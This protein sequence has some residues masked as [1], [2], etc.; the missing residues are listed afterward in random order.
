MSTNGKKTL[1][2]GI[3]LW[4]STFTWGQIK[5]VYNVPSPEV[6]SL[7][8]Y[9]S[10]PVGHF[11]GIP[12][13]SIPLYEVKMGSFSLPITASYHLASVKPTTT[14][15]VLGFGWS[16]NAGGYITRTVRFCYDE[17]TEKKDGIPLGYY[18]N[19]TKMKDITGQKFDKMMD[20]HQRTS[21][22]IDLSAD[23]FHFNFCGYTG[24]FYYA[25]DGTWKVIS[26]Q[27]IKVEFDAAKDG[28]I[29]LENIKNDKQPRI[30]IPLAW[31]AAS[32]NNR[33]FH[34]FTLVTPDGYR[35]EFGGIH[36]MEFSISY[37]SRIYEDLIPTTWWLSKITS[38]SNRTISFKYQTDS[39]TCDLKY[40]PQLRLLCNIEASK[41]LKIY[42]GLLGYTGF[43]LF[44]A[45][46]QS[47]STENETVTF[48]YYK[49]YGHIFKQKN[50]KALFWP[51]NEGEQIRYSGYG[52]YDKLRDPYKQFHLFLSLNP[53]NL[54][55]EDIARALASNILSGM[56]I[57][58]DN[59]TVEQA[60]NFKY[61]E[62]GMKKLS[63]ITISEIDSKGNS[64][65][66][67]KGYP[68]YKFYYNEK[69]IQ[70]PHIL[71]GTDSWGYY[72]GRRKRLADRPDFNQD[73]PVPTNA[74][75]ETL[76]EIIYPTGGKTVFKYESNAYSK[77]VESIGS[78]LKSDG[79]YH[80]SGGLR[81]K[82]INNINADDSLMTTTRYYYTEDK[83][84]PN[85]SSGVSKNE[86]IQYLVFRFL[87]GSTYEFGSKGGIFPETVDDNS[88]SVGY[89]YVIEEKFDAEGHSNGHIRYRYSNF[90]TD[91]ESSGHLD[92]LASH[93][94]HIDKDN[95]T[96]PFTS[97][98]RER[99]KLLSKEY[100]DNTGKLIKREDIKYRR[101]EDKPFV[102]AHQRYIFLDAY[103][104]DIYIGWLT[105]THTYSYL[106]VRTEETTYF[107]PGD[108]P[109]TT[110]KEIEYTENKMIRTEKEITSKGSTLSTEYK[111]VSDD[112]QYSWLTNRHI[113]SSLI[114]K[115]TS[116]EGQE[117]K[118]EY[119]YTQKNGIPYLSD[120]NLTTNEPAQT[121]KLY[122]VLETDCYANPISLF[123]NG[124]T[125]TL[126]WG[127]KG[128]KLIAKIQN[129]AYDLIK[130]KLGIDISSYSRKDLKDINYN[131]ITMLRT[132]L[133]QA[134]FNIY[135]Y[136]NALRLVSE[137]LP[138]GITTYYKYDILGRLRESYFYD[139]LN[140]KST[141][142][143]YDYHY[144]N[145]PGQ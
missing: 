128:Q 34:K 98:S 110:T 101:T 96:F 52:F 84:R 107:Q 46:I 3:F 66:K 70:E 114:S 62:N 137:T 113:L 133:P 67:G 57:R 76:S 108:I 112:N 92:E 17:R 111:Y 10:I 122:N 83:K 11:T 5:P 43:L 12:D 119:A 86:I 93:S 13:I 95:P 49:D 140:G 79:G 85:T 8:Q 102:V 88:P 71:A 42:K 15:N 145:N 33:F 74:I 28:F 32:S 81:I 99:G 105:N 29:S 53:D 47:I 130:F 39:R 26:D 143:E 65:N 117:Q 116:N 37:Y 9:G 75:A 16:L 60:I 78:S 138:N 48:T 7:G 51:R 19:V 103:L 25:P 90:D 118:E 21:Q 27:D 50:T 41:P 129:A 87:D 94:Y 54:S 1:L 40:V 22:Y 121:V 23:E 132:L 55:S 63:N 35:Y 134:Y 30:D 144:Y 59:D 64:I 89:S 38:P 36:A 68:E 127:G 135:K 61:T 2:W 24:S 141:L 69:I 126:I 6:A 142:Q 91:I 77:Q 82:E 125:Y 139:V 56:T 73:D 123:D 4:L 18:D 72:D 80:L 20:E 131:E 136:D 45:N 124:Q 120:I 58:T 97:N 14:V 115:T 31:G 104:Q 109:F 44:P 100:F 106:P